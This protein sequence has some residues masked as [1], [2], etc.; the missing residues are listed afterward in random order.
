MAARAAAA[1]VLRQQIQL[2]ARRADIVGFIAAAAR[3]N[4]A[5]AGIPTLK[6]DTKKLFSLDQQEVSVLP[7]GQLRPQLETLAQSKGITNPLVLTA[8]RIFAGRQLITNPT[9][10][11]TKEI[12]GDIK[13]ALGEGFS[14]FVPAAEDAATLSLPTVD[15]P[16]PTSKG[17]Q[18]DMAQVRDQIDTMYDVHAPYLVQLFEAVNIS[19]AD[20]E[21]LHKDVVLCSKIHWRVLDAIQH[22]PM[23]QQLSDVQDFLDD[24]GLQSKELKAVILDMYRDRLAV[25]VDPRENA[26]RIAL[27]IEEKD[28]VYNF[29]N[30]RRTFEHVTA[31]FRTDRS[32]VVTLPHAPSDAEK[33]IIMAELYKKCDVNSKVTVTFNTNKE[34]LE[35]LVIADGKTVHDY[36]LATQLK[37]LCDSIERMPK[38]LPSMPAAPRPEV[39]APVAGVPWKMMEAQEAQLY[40]YDLQAL[41]RQQ[42][43][44]ETLNPEHYFYP[45]PI[46]EKVERDMATVQAAIDRAK[47][48]EAKAAA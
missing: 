23:P 33:K 28:L 32:F 2:K 35:G 14:A 5:E 47:A 37:S 39:A 4:P 40:G 44:D 15:T 9:E 12:V 22:K 31:R 18:L 27:T 10:I 3:V 26:D 19:G 8:L 36:S 25:I 42:S 13:A 48:L 41:K 43:A 38:S 30:F 17:T 11:D 20:L 1:S 24:Q 16:K 34:L 21:A 7:Y 29:D 45:A 46:V 6:S